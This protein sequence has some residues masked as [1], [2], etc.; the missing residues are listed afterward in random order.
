MAYPVFHPLSLAAR[1]RFFR[2]LQNSWAIVRMNL[3]DGRSVF[4]L[5]GRI[6][7][8]LLIGR[9]VV[10]PTAIAVDERDHVGGIFTDE[11]KKL[12]AL[13][14]LASNAVELQVLIDRVNIEEQNQ[15]CQP[16]YPFPEIEPVRSVGL[17]TKPGKSE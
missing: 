14:Q 15:C 8:D 12:I 10:Q 6:P 4:Q 5:L 9:A 7:K 17:P 11:L 16:T 1:A 2:C 3:L 13:C